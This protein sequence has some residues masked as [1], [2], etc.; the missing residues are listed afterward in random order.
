MPIHRFFGPLLLL[1]LTAC[2]RFDEARFEEGTR[3]MDAGRYAEAYCLWRPLAERGH[4]A[5]Q[6][7]IGWMYAN[8]QGMVLDEEAALPWWRRAA[9][10]GHP[11][12]QFAVA[13]AYLNG[14][15]V[16]TDLS[17]AVPWLEKAASQGIEDAA[18]LLRDLAG[19]DVE[20][21]RS[22][23]QKRLKSREWRA[24]GGV[25]RVKADRANLREGIG[26]DKALVASL[27][28]GAEVM[29][30]RAERDW[31]RIGMPGTGELAWIYEPLLE[32]EEP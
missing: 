11:D 14:S 17:Q 3:A 7:N 21:A 5:A 4:A 29:V 23:V 6:Y 2:G 16:K 26:T 28:Q 15:G 20:P 10:G 24:L 12:A 1:T 25:R 13:Q 30:L 19:R 18:I 32:P 31:L 27:D 9:E 8:G 22:L